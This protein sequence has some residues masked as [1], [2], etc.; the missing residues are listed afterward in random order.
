VITLEDLLV[1]ADGSPVA[2]V[3]DR[4]SLRPES[5]TSQKHFHDSDSTR[6]AIT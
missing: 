1:L 5:V 6:F 4:A 2:S 3:A